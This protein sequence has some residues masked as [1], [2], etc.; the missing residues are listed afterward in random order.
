MSDYEDFSTKYQDR[1]DELRAAKRRI[2]EI[3]QVLPDAGKEERAKLLEERKSLMADLMTGPDDLGELA[4]RVCLAHLEIF[5]ADQEQARAVLAE[6]Q[7]AFD[8]VEAE[9]EAGKGSLDALNV[10]EQKYFQP[11]FRD[12][13]QPLEDYTVRKAEIMDR[14]RVLAASLPRAEYRQAENEL[15]K[16][17]LD[18]AAYAGRARSYYNAELD[19]KTLWNRAAHNYGEKARA[20]ANEELLGI[21]VKSWLGRV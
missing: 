7:A 9:M 4:R 12:Q 10:E 13:R 15:A 8:Q 11:A 16:A 21:G 1:L 2:E 20:E 17:R 18:F 5:A 14:R 3:S 19:N 6:K